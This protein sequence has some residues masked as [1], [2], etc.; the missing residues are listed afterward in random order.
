ML[1]IDWICGYAKAEIID[2]QYKGTEND[3][4]SAINITNNYLNNS[5]TGI[6]FSP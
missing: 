4:C 5:M 1:F 3:P 6:N 2:I